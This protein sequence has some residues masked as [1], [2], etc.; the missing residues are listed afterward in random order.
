MFVLANH[1][2]TKHY[3]L[4]NKSLEGMLLLLSMLIGQLERKAELK[5]D[6]RLVDPNLAVLSDSALSLSAVL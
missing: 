6:Y 5:I 4:L 1:R 3:H 2:V